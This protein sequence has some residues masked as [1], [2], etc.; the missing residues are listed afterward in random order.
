MCAA[1]SIDHFGLMFCLVGFCQ[2]LCLC[3]KA[4][5]VTHE[6]L[7][8]LN[9][10]TQ[11]AVLTTAAYSSGQKNLRYKHAVSSLIIVSWDSLIT[12]PDANSLRKQV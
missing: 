12:F 8:I 2:F 5:R 10:H 1:K 3:S 11:T 4:S 7:Q 6:T 9:T